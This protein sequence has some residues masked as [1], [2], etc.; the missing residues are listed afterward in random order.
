MSARN[1]TAEAMLSVLLIIIFLNCLAHRNGP[2]TH[3]VFHRMVQCTAIYVITRAVSRGILPGTYKVCE[4][5]ILAMAGAALI[6]QVTKGIMQISGLEIRENP[7]FA[8]TGSFS[9]PGPYG[10]FIAICTACLWSGIRYYRQNYKWLT[11]IPLYGICLLP[12]TMSRAALLAAAVAI[13]TECAV[14]HRGRISLYFKRRHTAA[15]I[16]VA[17]LTTALTAVSLTAY[18][19]KKE[20]ADGRILMARIS[21]QAMTEKPLAGAGP[22][23]Y[24]HA[25]GEAQY[26][27]FA[28]YPIS[29]S[30]RMTA[31]SPE[32][33]FNTFLCAGVEYGIPAMILLIATAVLLTADAIRRESPFGYG[34]LAASVFACLSYPQEIAAFRIMLPII[35][36]MCAGSAAESRRAVRSRERATLHTVTVL[37]SAIALTAV[38]VSEAPV[39]QA[40]AEWHSHE[41]LVSQGRYRQAADSMH[42]LDSL[43]AHDCRFLFQYGQ[44]LL[45]SGNPSEGERILRKGA[46]ISCDPMFWNLIGECRRMQGD[47]DGA[48]EC[49]RRA[50]YTVPNRLYPICLMARMYYYAGDIDKFRKYCRKAQSFKPKIESDLTR[51][52]RAELSELAGK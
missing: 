15:L 8:C 44:A 23:M 52:M 50:F 42:G 39:R 2:V 48:A 32:Y 10:G 9:N 20:S 45:K 18:H 51:S 13:G 27:H 26:R 49:Y 11:I 28:E 1:K 37:A 19:A 25:Y 30:E 33:P 46:A 21:L 17:V 38:R 6:W 12:A 29:E 5:I 31:D 34:L 14:H 36:A 41:H 22:G 3:I 47:T 40:A 16:S 43:L 24:L 35:I 7:R 4:R